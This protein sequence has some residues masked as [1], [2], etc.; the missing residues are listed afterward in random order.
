MNRYSRKLVALLVL[1]TFFVQLMS[2]AIVAAQEAKNQKAQIEKA[3]ADYQKTYDEIMA[4]KPIE[5]GKVSEW[6]LNRINDIKNAWNNRPTWLGGKDRSEEE[7]A[8]LKEKQ[9]LERYVPKIEKANDIKKIQEDQNH[10]PA[11][12]GSFR[13]S[14]GP[15]RST[16]PHE[17]ASALG[18]TKALKEAGKAL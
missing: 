9:E 15:T 8:A 2:P 5:L 7:K 17:N 13:R 14:T 10:G 3:V 12:A 18:I 1:F 6:T 16:K 11:Q 4:I